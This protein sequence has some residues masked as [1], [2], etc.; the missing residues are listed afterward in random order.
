MPVVVE[1]SR[2]IPVNAQSAFTAALGIPLPTL[3]P[4]RYGPFPPI[5]TVR[6][7]ARWAQVGDSRT[8]VP[9]GG[10]SMLETLTGVDGP[11]SFSYAVTEIKGPMALLVDHIDG[12]W[13]F[14]PLGAGTQASWQWTLH[15]TSAL[16]AP[17]VA[18][19]GRLWHGYARQALASLADYALR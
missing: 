4:R 7:Q 17:V 19:L 11:G 14:T 2:A 13:S 6:G 5:R 10:G 18:L 8:I 15:P 16:T 9:A 1:Q 3:L 12:Q